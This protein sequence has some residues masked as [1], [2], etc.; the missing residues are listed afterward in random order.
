M[1]KHQYLAEV[2]FQLEKRKIEL[3]VK[4]ISTLCVLMMFHQDS[5]GFL[6]FFLN[7]LMTYPMLLNCFNQYVSSPHHTVWAI[8]FKLPFCIIIIILKKITIGYRKKGKE[9][10]K[11]SII[12][13]IQV[14][15]VELLRVWPDIWEFVAEED[16]RVRGRGSMCGTACRG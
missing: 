9:N 2:W 16:G 1:K 6:S 13:H 3:R 14:K 8:N 12:L 15:Q 7:F 5:I 11:H 10:Q 4:C